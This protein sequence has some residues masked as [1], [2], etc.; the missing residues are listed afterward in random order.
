[1]ARSRTASVLLV[2]AIVAVALNQ[3]PAVVA[4]APVLGDLRA[5]TGLSS[6]LAGL[7]TTL[8]VLCFGAFAPAAPRLARRIGLETAVALS[9]LLLAAGIALRLL[10]PVSLLFA[11]GVL[12]GAAIAFANVLMPA[13]VKREFSRPGLVMGFYSASLN[14]G[15]AAGAAL[16]VPLAEALGLDW[17]AA[18]GLWLALALAALAL[19]LPVAG[20]GRAHRTSDPLPDDAGSWSLLRQP[21]ARQVTAYLGLQSVQFYTVAAWLPTLLA[22]S[23]VPVREGGLMLGLANVVGAGGALLAPAQAGRMRTQRPLILAVAASYTVGLGGLLIAPGTGTLLWVAAFGLAQ[24]GGF[25]LALTLI[26]LRSPTPLVAARL[27]G[28]AQCLGYLLAA[29]GPLALGAL[30]DATGGWTS[31][32]A[33]LLAVLV[34]MTWFGW[35]AARS[36]V[37]DAGAVSGAS[38]EDARTPVA[39]ADPVAPAGR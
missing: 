17:R 20:T 9:L 7:L 26:V 37:L 25:A 18:L 19:W 10:S 34:P 5:D 21:L 15:A 11:G 24:G 6:T 27:G 14:I 38:P 16:T 29:L 31:P 8:P 39:S 28:V 1:V 32:V 4:V 36:A 3:R 2:A 12:A 23:G 33:L 35:G 30:H 22:D 13:Y